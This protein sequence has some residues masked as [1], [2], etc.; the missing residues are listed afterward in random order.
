MRYIYWAVFAA[1]L[2]LIVC[3]RKIFRREKRGIKALDVVNLL[4]LALGLLFFYATDGPDNIQERAASCVHLGIIALSFAVTLLDLKYCWVVSAFLGITYG[5]LA[6]YPMLYNFVYPYNNFAEDIL[7]AVYSPVALGVIVVLAAALTGGIWLCV[8]FLG[9]RHPIKLMSAALGFVICVAVLVFGARE[10]VKPSQQ[11]NDVAPYEYLAAAEN[12]E[13]KWGFINE[14]GEVVLP[15]VYGE[16]HDSLGY[17]DTFLAHV[18]DDTGDYL[19]NEKGKYVRDDCTDYIFMDHSQYIIA[20]KWSDYGIIDSQGRTVADFVYD[21]LDELLEDYRELFPRQAEEELQIL[22]DLEAE[23]F[24]DYVVDAEG[25]VIIP[26][27]LGYISF[28]RDH[29]Y[30]LINAGWFVTYEN[31]DKHLGGC[32]LYDRQGNAVIPLTDS[33]GLWADSENGWI[34]A[35]DLDDRFYFIDADENV[36]LDLG[37]AYDYVRGMTGIRKG[38]NPFL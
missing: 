28:S 15:F 34:L 9:A 26:S 33:R 10:A 3:V 16:Y 8:R 22:S 21:D 25:N 31:T 27:N 17:A 20:E 37:Y 35:Q 5:L 29:Q 13:G 30:F 11:A 24:S 12:K 2:I 14:R 32:G 19:I 6:A 4:L 7:W 36:M 38:A 18:S 23:L 1:A